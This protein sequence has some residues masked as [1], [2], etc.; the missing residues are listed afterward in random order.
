ML[1]GLGMSESPMHY[2]VVSN[3][4]A[5]PEGQNYNIK[6]RTSQVRAPFRALCFA[7]TVLTVRARGFSECC[8]PCFYSLKFVLVLCISSKLTTCREAH[9][10]VLLVQ[11]L[12]VSELDTLA[13]TDRS[14]HTNHETHF[15]SD[16][17]T[18]T[19]R[20]APHHWWRRGNCITRTARNNNFL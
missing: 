5:T 15:E 3:E 6:D 4:N 9:V 12:D 16:T 10:S 11:P 19:S 2:G 1:F 18:A 14:M 13:P 7:V 17:H 20:V 8:F